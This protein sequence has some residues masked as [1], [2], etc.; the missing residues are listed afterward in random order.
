MVRFVLYLISFG[1]FSYFVACAPVK[2][3]KDA[4]VNAC[5]NFGQDCVQVSGYDKFDYSIAVGGGQVDILF[6]DDNSGS[7]SFEQSKIA[8]KFPSFLSGLDSRSLDYRI[9]IVTTDIESID[10]PKRPINGNGALQNGNLISFSDGSNFLSS[11]SADKETLFRNAIKRSET[12]QCDSYIKSAQSGGV[13]RNS[14]SYISG[15]YDNCPSPDERGVYAALMALQKSTQFVR[16]KAHLGIVFI[17]DENNRS[18]GSTEVYDK[19]ALEKN[20]LP[21]NLVEFVSSNYKG[22]K[23]LSMH[24][25]VVNTGDSSCLTQQ[26]QQLS[27]YVSGNYGT[28]YEKA[29]QLTGGTIGSVCASDYGA[30]LANISGAIVNQLNSVMLACENPEDFTY[31]LIPADSSNV[32]SLQGRNLTFAKPVAPNSVVHLRYSCPTL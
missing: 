12:L 6:V 8:D 32:G 18:Y 4:T 25:I 11:N 21:E 10:N 1:I 19:Y 20:D 26:N 30:Q 5:Q 9:G 22:E 29:A 15:Y 24:A 2:F 3:Q 23:S 16:S 27:G 28:S 31:D 13:S 17:S 7:M 14:Q